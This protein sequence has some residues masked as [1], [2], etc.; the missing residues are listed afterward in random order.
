[1]IQHDEIITILIA[2][3]VLIFIFSNFPRIRLIRSWRL[4]LAAFLTLFAAWTATIAEGFLWPDFF[5]TLEHL[6]YAGCTILMAAW[7]WKA[8]GSGRADE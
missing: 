7:T 8:T 1:M 6:G 4:L 5:N 3:G 2:V